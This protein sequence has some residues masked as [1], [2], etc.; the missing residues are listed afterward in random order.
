MDF[1]S[2]L[3]EVRRMRRERDVDGLITALSS[4]AESR[5]R[6]LSVR[7]A[8]A[9]D[10]G[11]LRAHDA[12]PALAEL[13]TADEDYYVRIAATVALGEIGDRELCLTR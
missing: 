13:A 1:D 12:V 10:L 5:H 3:L 4:R 11:R 9:R 6:K 2:Q 7:A 8:A